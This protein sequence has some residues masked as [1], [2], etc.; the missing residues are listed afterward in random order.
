[1]W[2]SISGIFHSL[3]LSFMKPIILSTENVFLEDNLR[4]QSPRSYPIL[5]V[6]YKFKEL[7]MHIG[8]ALKNLGARMEYRG[9]DMDQTHT[10]ENSESGKVQKI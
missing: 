9:S 8:V 3:S 10:Q 1:M 7:P 5:G 2:S 4:S 6:Q